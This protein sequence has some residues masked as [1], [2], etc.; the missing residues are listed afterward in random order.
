MEL[1]S[2]WAPWL[3]SYVRLII[4][5]QNTPFSTLVFE[6]SEAFLMFRPTFLFGSFNRKTTEPPSSM[7]RSITALRHFQPP[8][9]E[10]IPIFSNIEK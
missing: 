7:L 4:V 6:I 1:H 10:K 8:C 5:P 3:L 2:N 9:E